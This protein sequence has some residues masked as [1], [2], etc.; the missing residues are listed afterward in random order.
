MSEK[1]KNSTQ[2]QNNSQSPS[3]PV[4]PVIRQPQTRIDES[5]SRVKTGG[6]NTKKGTGQTGPG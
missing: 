6:D 1:G 2:G 4:K 5:T 3:S